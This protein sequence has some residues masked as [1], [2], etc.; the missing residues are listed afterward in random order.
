MDFIE[1]NLLDGEKVIY[2]AKLHW[3]IFI[4][5]MLF[6][7]ATLF[8]YTGSSLETLIYKEILNF[9][10]APV[11]FGSLFTASVYLIFVIIDYNTTE[12]VVTNKRI[13]RKKGFISRYS[14]DIKLNMIETVRLSQRVLGR[15]FNY[16]HVYFTGVG[17][18]TQK[19][20]GIYDPLEL[21]N[22]IIKE[23]NIEK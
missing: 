14:L 19:F 10:I 20:H 23:I 16:G 11:Q 5:P 4:R 17:A 18:M 8:S 21:R 3:C 6:L 15:I 13:S 1:S 12:I 2:R 7:W 22:I 9:F